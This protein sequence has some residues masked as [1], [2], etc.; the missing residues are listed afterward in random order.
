MDN[1]RSMLGGDAQP[2]DDDSDMS[3]F[4]SSTSSTSSGY[5]SGS[6]AN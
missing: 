4:V 3:R 1:Y 6:S 2:Q 5:D